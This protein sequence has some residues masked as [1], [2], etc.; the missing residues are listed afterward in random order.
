M[1]SID[2]YFDGIAKKFATNIYGTT[3]GRLRHLLLVE[4]LMPYLQNSQ[5]L[6]VMDLGG[7]TGIMT[8][9]VA[10]AG[11]EVTLVDASEDVLELAREYLAE[12][13]GVT[14]RQ[15]TIQSEKDIAQQDLVICH[16]V[17]EW[18]AEPLAAVTD[19]YQQM[20]PGSALSL[21][22]FNRDA[23][24]FGNAVYG[25]FDYI[26]RGMKVKNQVRLNPNNPL[27]PAE[28][29][30]H[31]ESLGFSVKSVTGIRCFHDYMKDKHLDDEQFEAL[32]ALEKQYMHQP[33]YCWLG[34]YIHLMLQKPA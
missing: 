34:K 13:P 19:I 33:P 16:A 9:V 29:I 20:K 11:H 1:K 25:N 14:I 10:D 22:F 26:S 21:T 12:V 32:V 17:L 28:V 27:V 8:K 6:K 3:K 30:A 15:G 4:T 7:G 2:Q 31:A 23:A 18:L 24:L 5:R